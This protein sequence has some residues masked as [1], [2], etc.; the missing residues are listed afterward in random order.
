MKSEASTTSCYHC[1]LALET[2]YRAKVFKLDIFGGGTHFG[3]L[4]TQTMIRLF[5]EV[6]FVKDRNGLSNLH[7]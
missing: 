4:Y 5:G 7:R 1:D 3:R 6:V 2:E